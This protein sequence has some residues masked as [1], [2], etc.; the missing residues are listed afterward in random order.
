[1][2]NIATN[3]D[4]A[5]LF[6]TIVASYLP[7]ILSYLVEIIVLEQVISQ[8][9]IREREIIFE[10]IRFCQYNPDWLG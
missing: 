6:L 4:Y 2:T 8:E 9:F 10:G 5:Y 7:D 1:M 3:Y